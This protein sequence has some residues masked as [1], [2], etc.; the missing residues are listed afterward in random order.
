MINMN[1]HNSYLPLYVLQKG[2]SVFGCFLN[3]C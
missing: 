1:A 2:D 3:I